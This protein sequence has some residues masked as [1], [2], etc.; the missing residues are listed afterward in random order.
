VL[1]RSRER[2]EVLTLPVREAESKP[3]P[4]RREA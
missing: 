1:A 3:E 4:K 2:H